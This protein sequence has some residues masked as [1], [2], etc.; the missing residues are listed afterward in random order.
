MLQILAKKLNINLQSVYSEYNRAVRGQKRPSV[1]V[2]SS[3]PSGQEY[4]A[5]YIV[6]LREGPEIFLRECLFQEEVLNTPTMTSVLEVLAHTLDDELRRSLELRFEYIT[7]GKTEEIIF[8]EFREL[9][10]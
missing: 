5:T 3:L 8:R 4:L 6:G 10:R 2:S 9:I 1:S 7:Q